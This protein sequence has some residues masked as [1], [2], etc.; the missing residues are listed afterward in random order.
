VPDDDREARFTEL[1]DA[2]REAVRAYLWR[3]DPQIADDVT[4]E[5]FLVCWRRLDA[6]P[7]EP[8]PWLIGV[9]RNLRLNQRRGEARR[10]RLEH[11]LRAEPVPAP[12]PAAAVGE[13]DALHAALRS[14]GERDREVLLLTAWERL[15]RDEIAAVLGCTR[16]NVAVR[17]LRARRR[18]ERELTIAAGPGGTTLVSHGGLS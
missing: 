8:L 4:A 2:H 7:E 18:L 12:D 13:R 5:T 11:R 17:L 1:F 10:A 16:A 15:G 6:V 3:R 9:A 14:L